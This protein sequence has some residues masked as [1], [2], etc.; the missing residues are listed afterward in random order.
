MKNEDFIN[1]FSLYSRRRQRSG[2]VSE[3]ASRWVRV[4]NKEKKA[5]FHCRNASG[6]KCLSKLEVV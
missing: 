6:I 4:P 3:L 2:E 1:E 5:I